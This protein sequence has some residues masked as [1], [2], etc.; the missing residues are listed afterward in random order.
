MSS[1]LGQRV[2]YRRSA[3]LLAISVA[4]AYLSSKVTISPFTL[5][6]LSPLTILGS[7][8]VFIGFDLWVSWVVDGQVR[9]RVERG[10]GDG[11]NWHNKSSATNSNSLRPH[12]RSVPPLIFT[13]PAAWSVTQTRAA[14]EANL[15]TAPPSQWP[16]ATESLS[17]QLNSLIALINRD[18]VQSWY[19]RISNSP[20]FPAAVDSTL[21]SAL[22]A[23]ATRA[24][25]VDWSTVLVNRLLPLITN[26]F[27]A[28]RTAELALRGQDLKV[29]L[30]ESAELDLFL[31]NRY[32]AESKQGRLHPAVDVASPNSRPAEE[33]WLSNLFGGIVPL[34]LPEKEGESAAVRIMVREI[35]AC[36][37]MVPVVETLSDPDF[38]NRTIDDKAGAAIRDQK[39][40]NQ[41]RQ[42]LDKQ[43]DSLASASTAH[44]SAARQGSVRRAGTLSRTEEIS[45][46]T[47]P[48]Q[49]EAFLRGIDRCTNL[50]DAKRLRS[51]VAGQIRK[52]KAAVGNRDG[53]EVVGGVKVATH[54]EH[55]AR[56]YGAK[57]RAD[58][59]IAALGGAHA[60]SVS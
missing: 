60:D 35:V 49:F 4:L 8:V 24:A 5:L 42:A 54:A 59:R 21:Q 43:G 29:P 27:A 28:F 55:I 15:A 34:I 58:E 10:Q 40:V 38:Y 51:D 32:A 16:G 46:H 19:S 17:A 22:L 50:L 52:A 36:A 7:A 2:S 25:K 30:T 11:S 6:I 13:S 39:M 33:R 44:L 12:P 9:A 37:V 18:F 20:A 53:K 56:L 3:A 26:H 45:V 57:Q 47:S 48:R 41:F 14:W 23:F 1:V 31:A